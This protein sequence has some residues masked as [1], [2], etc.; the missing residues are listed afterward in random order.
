M[1]SFS[2]RQQIMRFLVSGAFATLVHW[3]VFALLTQLSILPLAATTYGAISGAVVNYFLQRHVVFASK[4]AHSSVLVPY[5][6]TVLFSFA[7]NA[8]L[9]F[10]I[11]QTQ[12]FPLFMIQVITSACV[13]CINFV[14]YKKVVFHESPSSPSI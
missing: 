1:F 11:Q 9:F 4:V 8:F 14:L 5:T 13:M 7:L 6:L 2:L 3:S 12:L 10:L